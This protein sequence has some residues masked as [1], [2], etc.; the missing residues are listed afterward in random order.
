MR[1]PIPVLLSR[2]S[3]LMLLLLAACATPRNN[4]D[5]LESINR[6]V[7]SFNKTVD[8][9][10][11][12]PVAKAWSDY[13]PSPVKKG[14]HNFFENIGDLFAIPPALLQGKGA[15]ASH[16]AARVIVNTTAGLGGLIDWASDIELKKSNEDFGQVLGFWGVPTGP[17]L[18]LP[19]LGPVTARDTIDPALRFTYGPTTYIDPESARYVYTGVGVVEGR[20][21]FLSLDK[22]LAE[23]YDQY[24]FLRDTYLQNRW[25]KVHD[26]NPPHP[27]KMAIDEEDEADLPPAVPASAKPASAPV[28]EAAK[29]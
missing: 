2:L 15:D 27:L 28:S 7:Y 21:Q 14:V 18:M 24:A 9:A 8:D 6:P 17:Y 3:V 23:Q 29:P 26:G 13:L 19:F 5:P 22:M 12:R 25:F 4:Y 10:V 11:L 1:I 20:A 16:S